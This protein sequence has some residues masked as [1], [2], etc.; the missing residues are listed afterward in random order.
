[1]FEFARQEIPAGQGEWH[2]ALLLVQ[3]TW[4]FRYF[5]STVAAKVYIYFALQSVLPG[6]YRVGENK[7]KYNMST[8]IQV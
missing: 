6:C 5:D 4:I 8:S 3:C 2:K 1:M 7:K